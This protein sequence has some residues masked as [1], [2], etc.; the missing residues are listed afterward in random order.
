MSA[1]QS[2]KKTKSLRVQGTFLSMQRFMAE[3]SRKQPWSTVH[4][5]SDTGFHCVH[6]ATTAAS[7]TSTALPHSSR[8]GTTGSAKSEVAGEIKTRQPCSELN[9]DSNKTHQHGNGSH[10][11]NSKHNHE[12][13]A[14]CNRADSP[15][16]IPSA[17]SY[18][19]PSQRREIQRREGSKNHDLLYIGYMFADA[20][21][22]GAK[23]SRNEGNK[24]KGLLSP[25]TT[26]GSMAANCGPRRSC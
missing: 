13:N 16:S 2:E 25:S 17:Q 23:P 7:Q 14:P 5:T 26:L 21:T 10:Q 8:A 24:T 12:S 22:A 4:L 6:M 18:G 9:H 1:N 19:D 3:D 11:D 20:G 15:P